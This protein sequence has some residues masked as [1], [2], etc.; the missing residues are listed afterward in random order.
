MD[1]PNFAHEQTRRDLE[2]GR[3]G[4]CKVC[5]TFMASDTDSFVCTSCKKDNKTS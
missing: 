2:E 3:A 5:K 1:H 4:P